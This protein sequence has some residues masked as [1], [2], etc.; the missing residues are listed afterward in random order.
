MQIN[1]VCNRVGRGIFRLFVW[2]LILPFWGQLPATAQVQEPS[3]EVQANGQIAVWT[4]SALLQKAVSIK[5]EKDTA[6]QRPMVFRAVPLTL[7]LPELKGVETV[8][9]VALDGFV[10]NI[11]G[12]VLAGK[13][14]PYL[15]IEDPAEVWPSL[16]PEQT[17]ANAKPIT[18]GPFYLVWLDPKAGEIVSEQWPYQVA[19][20][21]VVLPL[22]ARF[23]QILPKS[24]LASQ[25]N[26]AIRGLDVFLKNCAVCHTV[27][28]G[29]DAALG[30]DLNLPVNPTE[31]FQLKYL[32]QL[33]RQPSS[34]RTWKQSA[35]PGF[36][37]ESISE[38]D[39]DNLILYLKQMA[40]QR[41]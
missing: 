36:D 30:P 1:R 4:R 39:M 5:L 3:L 14:K 20:I 24:M 17:T 40:K 19:Q 33:I 34:V 31:Y 32:R 22:T 27:N 9:F 41:Q 6:Y 13:G 28:G 26:Q 2:V 12:A 10:A 8:Q 37:Q 21:K 16:K 18:A 25:Q 29:G 11:S 38:R 23:P 7:L 15:A 35:M